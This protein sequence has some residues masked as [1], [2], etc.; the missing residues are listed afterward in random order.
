VPAE[1]DK[2]FIYYL[3]AGWSKSGDFSAETDWEKYVQQFVARLRAP[4]NVTLENE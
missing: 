2:P 4:L 3:G 1:A